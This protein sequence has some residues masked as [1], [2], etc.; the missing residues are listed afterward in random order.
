M[1]DQFGP[2]SGQ[3]WF[4]LFFSMLDTGRAA[5]V[6]TDAVRCPLLCVRGTDDRVVSHGT[7]R[8]TAAAHPGSAFWEPSGHGHM[9]L[10]EPGAATLAGCIARWA[11]KHPC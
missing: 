5:A 2:E 9:L 8:A 1:L 3:A 10:V 11:G 7:A 6:D 4:E